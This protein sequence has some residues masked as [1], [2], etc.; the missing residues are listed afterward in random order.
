ML[1]RFKFE[2]QKKE[3]GF[4][5]KMVIGALACVAGGALACVG[6]RPPRRG[7]AAASARRP[8]SPAVPPPLRA[9]VRL[10]AVAPPPLR[11]PALRCGAALTPLEV[12]FG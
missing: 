3:F 11:A 7:L 4:D 12:S 6:A 10:A 1:Y 5:I 8:A 2:K 9:P